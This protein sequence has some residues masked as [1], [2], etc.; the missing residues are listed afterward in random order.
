MRL[1][2]FV[3]ALA[4]AIANGCTSGCDCDSSPVV[5]GD[6]S[7]VI[8]LG[9]VDQ[10]DGKA[11]FSWPATGVELAFTGRDLWVQ[12]RG[13]PNADFMPEM[14][15][16]AIYVD[17]EPARVLTIDGGTH[18]NRLAEGLADAPHTVRI[19]KLTEPAVGTVTIEHFRLC[20]G[21]QV[22]RSRPRLARA[23]EA[24]GDSITAGFG[25]LGGDP[26]CPFSASTENAELT[27]TAIAARELHAEY[28]AV[29]WSGKGVA[30]N[31]DPSEPLTLPEIYDRVLP[32]EAH[33]WDHR[34]HP[35]DA[36]IVNLG[37]NDTLSR[38][39]PSDAVF[40]AAY[41]RFIAHLRQTHPRSLIV[42]VIGPM[43]YDEGE[44]LFRSRARTAIQSVAA[45]ARAQG[46]QHIEVLELWSTAEEGYGCQFHPSAT[47]H[48][49][50]A[51]ELTTLL[52]QRLGW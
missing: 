43:L 12:L 1:P 22:L 30:I 24:V 8:P 20:D 16:V 28:S 37:T 42:L 51:T 46:D 48:R 18:E 2:V 3:L 36:V 33:R 49:R 6:D 14:D 11:R 31:A 32:S 40:E 38:T 15:R 47:T 23:V 29:A 26:Q 4:L 44:V 35:V 13:T 25:V 17:R 21:G 45:T 39:P 27:Y 19:V 34:S 52:R 50:L 7:R 10:R 5:R 9:R 41:G